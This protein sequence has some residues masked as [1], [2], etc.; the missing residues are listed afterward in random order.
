MAKNSWQKCLVT[1]GAGFIGS[2]LVQSLLDLNKD[3]KV[4][5]DLSTGKINNLKNLN[6][7]NFFQGCVTDQNLLK[8]LISDVEVIFHLAACVSVQESMSNPVKV[9]HVNAQATLQLFELCKV[10]N[11]NVKII[12]ASS[13]AVYG[14]H[15]AKNL[16]EELNYDCKSM[17]ALSKAQQEQFAALYCQNYGLKS[18]SLRFFNVFGP[19]QSVDSHYAAVIP[20]FFKAA[21]NN[22]QS[23][24]FGDGG[25]TRDFVFVKDVVSANIA[26]ANVEA[27]GVFNVGTN[28]AISIL[29]LW[30]EISAFVEK[31]LEP[32][33][34]SERQGDVRHSV[35]NIDKT[36][37]Y[38]AW[39]PQT[40]LKEG[41][42]QAYEWYA[43]HL[44]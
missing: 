30:Q 10:M 27:Q 42:T 23:T 15:D 33:L 21:I 43:A 32:E 8:E 1:G 18:V 29:E 12:Q 36:K 19:R 31:P 22:K 2:H 11:P 26:A 37:A 44:I 34:K 25:Q 7:D 28:H 41:L 5:D 14:D 38:L 20:N 4:L 17:Y 6:Q 16:H 35:A 24:I 3:V 13:S 9:N 40:S 39:E